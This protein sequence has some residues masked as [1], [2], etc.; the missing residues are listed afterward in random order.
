MERL[1]RQAIL[2]YRYRDGREETLR[3][4]AELF[5]LLLELA[6]GYQ[7]G[8]VSSDDTFAN[9]SIFVQRLVQEDARELFVWNPMA[10]ESIYRVD[11]ELRSTSDLPKQFFSIARLTRG[12]IPPPASG[13]PQ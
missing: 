6:D 11:A 9:L 1:H 10:D 7:L 13:E 4:G 5:H 8:D 2:T 3:L 12:S